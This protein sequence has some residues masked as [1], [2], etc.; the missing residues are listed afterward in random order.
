MKNGVKLLTRRFDMEKRVA[1]S[2]LVDQM[3]GDLARW[4][5]LLGYDTHYSKDL[6][7]EDLIEQSRSENRVL[8]TCDQSLHKKAL[9][10]GIVSLL[11]RPDTL[12]KRLAHLVTVYEL[13]M[14]LDPT[15]S[16]C[17]LCN[18]EIEGATDKSKIVGK[19]PSKVIEENKEFWVCKNCGK[20]YWVGG[21]WENMRK[22]IEEVKHQLQLS[23]NWQL[24]D[25]NS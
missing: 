20:I 18:G 23:S 24:A 3:L 21:H 15:L 2:F 4:L 8:L 14:N 19:I 11:L 6:D 7:D 25:Q 12:V 22:T 17:P 16:R 1:P 13:E 5:R 9:K 10:K